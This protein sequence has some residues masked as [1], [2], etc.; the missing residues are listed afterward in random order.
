MAAAAPAVPADAPAS[1][2]EPGA[3]LAVT[4]LELDISAPD[5]RAVRLAAQSLGRVL[6]AEGGI[7]DKDARAARGPLEEDDEEPGR[8]R[9]PRASTGIA[10]RLTRAAEERGW[11]ADR[12]AEQLAHYTSSERGRAMPAGWYVSFGRTEQDDRTIDRLLDTVVFQAAPAGGAG[13]APA[14]RAAAPDAVRPAAGAPRPAPVASAARAAAPG[15]APALPAPAARPVAAPP[16]P[17]AERAAAGAT[18]GAPVSAPLLQLVASAAQPAEQTIR[19]VDGLTHE[20]LRTVILASERKRILATFPALLVRAQVP[21]GVAVAVTEGERGGDDGRRELWIA[22]VA[23]A[24]IIYLLMCILNESL[25]APLTVMTTVPAGVIAVLGVFTLARLPQ[26]QMVVLGLFLLVGI[27][28]NHGVVLVDR[29][30]TTVPM[31]R[32]AGR[33]SLLAVAAAARRRFTPVLLTSLTTIAGALPMALS[34]GRVLDAPIASLGLALAIGLGA[35]TVFTLIVVPIVY[36][37]LGRT[38]AGLVALLCG[39]RNP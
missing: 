30:A 23:A 35:A 26:D 36:Q 1:D 15:R 17:A 3:G 4:A 38:R 20:H 22:L 34:H 25:L 6:V 32:L 2:P 19:R 5:P 7:P 39:G 37:W 13:V 18:S 12:I 33:R 28:V 16:A 27:V 14:P 24:A 11:Q 8:A 29:L 31:H 10:L 9:G 21:D